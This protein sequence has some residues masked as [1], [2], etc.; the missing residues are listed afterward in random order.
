MIYNRITSAL[1]YAAGHPLAL[2]IAIGAVA[3]W[4]I[5]GPFLN[6]SDAWQLTINTSTTI[7]TF[8]MV[9]VIQS[10]QNRDTRALQIKLDELIKINAGARNS[11]LNLED[12]SESELAEI[13]QEYESL[14]KG[15]GQAKQKRSGAA[16]DKNRRSAK[17]STQAQ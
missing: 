7:V 16:Q 4:A 2:L 17:R 14:A 8:L 3:L 12:R 10:S 13:Q 6:F 1:S 15:A 5:S 11:L 9:F